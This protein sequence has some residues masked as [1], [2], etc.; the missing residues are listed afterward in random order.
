MLRAPTPTPALLHPKTQ[1]KP[2][3]ASRSRRPLCAKQTCKAREGISSRAFIHLLLLLLDLLLL[4]ER[5]EP[6]GMGSNIRR[7]EGGPT[8]RGSGLTSFSTLRQEAS[9]AVCT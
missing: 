7:K 4:V 6:P 5:G 3:L 9:R 1:N 8:A 2:A